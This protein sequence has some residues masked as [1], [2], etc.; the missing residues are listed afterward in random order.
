MAGRVG[1][2]GAARQIDRKPMETPPFDAEMAPK[3]PGF[4][5]PARYD[6]P[7][8]QDRYRA[9]LLRNLVVMIV[10]LLELFARPLAHYSPPL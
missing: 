4:Y 1:F 9:R 8:A 3:L 2:D 6:T 7:A 10:R 5:D